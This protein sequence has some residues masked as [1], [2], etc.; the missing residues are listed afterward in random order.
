MYKAKFNRI[1]VYLLLLY[2]IFWLV[3]CAVNPVTGKS[4]F[5]LLTEADEIKLGQQTDVEIVQMYGIYDNKE[6]LAYIDNLGQQMVKKSHRPNLKF[7]FR[8]MDSPVIN[9][10]AVPGGY[11]YITR[12]ILAYLNNEA[13]L[14]GVIGHEIGHV[15]ARHSAKQ[16]TNAQFAQLGLGLGSVLSEEFARYAPIAA[17]G[18]G[19]LFLKFSRDNESQS[20]DL[21]VEYSTKIGYDAHEMANFFVT[22]DKMSDEGQ[23]RALPS[24]LSTHPNPADRVTEIRIEADKWQKQLNVQGLKTNRNVYLNTINGLVFGDN[25]RQGFVE[26]NIFY[27]PDMKFKFPV[28]TGWQL[29]NMPTQVQIVSSDE[30]AAILFTLSTEKTTQAAAQKF[31]TNTKAVVNEQNDITVNGL[32]S[33]KLISTLTGQNT[34]LNVL[35]YFIEKDQY[36]FVFHGMT[37]ANLFNTYQSI[38]QNTMNGFSHLADKSKLNVTPD[39]IRIRQVT[40]ATN[41]RA[42]LKEFSAS[43][44]DLPKLAL[45]NGMNLEDA[46]SPNTLLKTID[47]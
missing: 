19:L 35:S 33:R 1:L 25:P 46:I 32:K 30:Q 34:N 47:R 37:S 28:P 39:R 20:D 40:H 44:D 42:A 11:V 29:T 5:M 21:G 4:E 12:G 41:L 2:S 17:Q 27:H 10:F 9:A 24:W 6:L 31:I 8:V 14:A 7:E 38:F 43:D 13:E 26:N 15:T 16:Y 36:I 3:A 22:L 45:M 23:S 18:I